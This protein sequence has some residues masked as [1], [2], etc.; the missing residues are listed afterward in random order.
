MLPLFAGPIINYFSNAAKI[1]KWATL[2]FRQPQPATDNGVIDGDSIDW[3]LLPTP[4]RASLSELI[5]TPVSMSSL[6]TTFD[7]VDFIICHHI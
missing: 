5:L 3:P 7:L 4:H 2:N 1:P 6:S